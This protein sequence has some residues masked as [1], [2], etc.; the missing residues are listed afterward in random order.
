MGM[1]CNGCGSNEK[2][3]RI[4]RENMERRDHLDFLCIGKCMLYKTGDVCMT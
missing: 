2:N 1:F 3:N 4:W